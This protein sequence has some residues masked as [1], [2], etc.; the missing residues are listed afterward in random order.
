M[1]TPSVQNPAVPNLSP[2]PARNERAEIRKLSHQLEG[3]FLNQLFQ[4]MR[5]TV[6]KGGVLEQSP[7]EEIFT[8]MMDQNLAARAADRMEHGLGEALY[9]QL[10]R[11]LPDD[12]GATKP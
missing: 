3:V 8:S 5:E 10:A 2:A 1:K 9:H 12:S 4:A 7:G 6:P 11:R